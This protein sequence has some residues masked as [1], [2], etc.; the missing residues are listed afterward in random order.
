MTDDD[1]IH[2][3]FDPAQMTPEERTQ[4]VAA[5]LARGYLRLRAFGAPGAVRSPENSLAQP[6]DQPPSCAPGERP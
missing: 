3:P 6:G 4:E 5:I 2:D 1:P